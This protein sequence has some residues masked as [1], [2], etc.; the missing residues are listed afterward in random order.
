[1]QEELIP[2][3]YVDVPD[4]KKAVP[5]EKKRSP[6][7][8][9]EEGRCCMSYSSVRPATFAAVLFKFEKYFL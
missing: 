1:M 3:V 6:K 5:D 4:D 2:A 8:E 7:R 9:K